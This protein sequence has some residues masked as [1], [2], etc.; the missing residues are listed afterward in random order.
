MHLV[1]ELLASPAAAKVVKSCVPQI[2]EAISLSSFNE[3]I[4]LICHV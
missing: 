4:L 1:L 2:T 3:G